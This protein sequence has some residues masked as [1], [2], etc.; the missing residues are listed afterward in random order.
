MSA[1][2]ETI[3]VFVVANHHRQA[4]VGKGKG[5]IV[6]LSRTIRCRGVLRVV[7]RFIVQGQDTDLL[8]LPVLRTV[9]TTAGH[10]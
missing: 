5:A 8:S 6:L 4:A 10:H 2:A 1:K 3:M 7:Q 9:P